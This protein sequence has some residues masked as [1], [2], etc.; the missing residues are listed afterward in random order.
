MNG[1]C[2][3]LRPAI[4]SLYVNMFLEWLIFGSTKYFFD[5]ENW[6]KYFGSISIG[7]QGS[8]AST[9]SIYPTPLHVNGYRV[10]EWRLWDTIHLCICGFQSWLAA[11]EMPK[12]FILS[13]ASFS[14]AFWSY[15]KSVRMSCVD[16]RCLSLEMHFI[17]C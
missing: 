14:Y 8:N 11:L 10:G 3:T 5:I 12:P 13:L 15:C 9:R 1:S 7:N 17:W 6:Q 4:F 16:C 2:N